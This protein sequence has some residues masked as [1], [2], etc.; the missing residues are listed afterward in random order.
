MV[1]TLSLCHSCIEKLLHQT[2]FE[3]D[4]YY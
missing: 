1:K 2:C 4:M 3:R